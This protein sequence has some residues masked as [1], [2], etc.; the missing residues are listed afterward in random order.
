MAAVASPGPA[1]AAGVAG[2]TTGS[3]PGNGSAMTIGAV[4][5]LVCAVS[6]VAVETSGRFGATASGIPAAAWFA[7]G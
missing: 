1:S 6:A 2:V 5:P 4:E 3:T 7:C